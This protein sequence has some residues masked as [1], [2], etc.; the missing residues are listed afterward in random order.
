MFAQ[1]NVDVSVVA[2]PI[3]LCVISIIFLHKVAFFRAVIESGFE[4]G[5]DERQLDLLC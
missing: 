5:F 1:H 2:D 4:V 3:A